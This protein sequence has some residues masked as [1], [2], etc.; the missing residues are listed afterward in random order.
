M[1]IN[2]E[3]KRFCNLHR[4]WTFLDANRLFLQKEKGGK[5]EIVPEMMEDALHPSVEGYAAWGEVIVDA[6]QQI[7]RNK[8]KAKAKRRRNR[9]DVSD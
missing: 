2:R 7:K 5:I 4:E 1:W 3:I 8:N 6:V 9:A